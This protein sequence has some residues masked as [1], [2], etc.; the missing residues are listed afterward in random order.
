MAFA[1]RMVFADIIVDDS[2]KNY[3]V[4][5]K[6]MGYQFDIRLG[7]YR[8]HFLSTITELSVKLDEEEVP[9]ET[10]KFCLNGKEFSPVELPNCYSE[11]W[12]PI[13]PATI[14]VWKPG[15][16]EAGEHHVAMT[17]MLRSP[18]MEIGPDQFMPIDSGGEKTL[19][20]IE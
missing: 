4:D 8:G 1:M 11:F 16:L 3:Y 17:L 13:E 2:L 7:Y 14:R 19:P 12:Q 20:V 5:G 9:A 6:K 15:G 18:Y 10:I